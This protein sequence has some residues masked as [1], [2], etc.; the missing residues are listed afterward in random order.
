MPP[1]AIDPRIGTA[2]EFEHDPS[3]SDD[4]IATIGRWV[5]AGAPQGDPEDMPPPRTFPSAQAWRIGHGKPDLVVEP[6]TDYAMPAKGSDEWIDF[7]MDPELTEDVW[8][9]E[10][11]VRP[12]NPHI[13]HHVVVWAVADQPDAST[14][15]SAGDAVTGPPLGGMQQLY[16][17]VPNRPPAVYP[18]NT[19]LLLRAGTKI[20]FSSH[21]SAS[22]ED[23]SDRTQLGLVFYKKGEVPQYPLRV[24]YFSVDAEQIDIAPNAITRINGYYRLNKPT[25]LRSWTPHMHQRGKAQTFQAILPNNQVKTLTRVSNYDFGWQITYQY[26]ADVA[27]LLPAGTVLHIDITYDNT[28]ANRTNPDPDRWVGYGSASTDEMG[29]AFIDF[30]ELDQAEFDRLVAERKA[31]ASDATS[32]NQ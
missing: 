14:S 30:V 8:V 10:L 15:G 7:V 22:G 12:S 20:R 27:P 6:E 5:S 17:F 3:L 9:K 31:K 19:G 24:E 26:A 11:E 18:D 21:Y 4:E 32:T 2:V 13:V 23:E 16:T 1:W 28:S 29:G 25:L